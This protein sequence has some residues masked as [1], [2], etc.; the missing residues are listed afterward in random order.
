MNQINYSFIVPV[1]NAEKYIEICLRSLLE[2]TADDYEIILID[3]GSS[4]RSP[5]ICDYFSENYEF[6]HTFHKENGGQV[7][8]RERGIIEAKGKYLCF[9]DSDDYISRDYLEHIDRIN[10]KY[11]SDI[12]IFNWRKVDSEGNVIPHNSNCLFTVGIV[13]KSA[14]FKKIISSSDLNSM[15][16]KV[17]KR[18]LFFPIEKDPRSELIRNGED[19]LQSLPAY[20]RA[21]KFYYSDDEL[22][23]YRMNENSV[24][25]TIRVDEYKALDIVRPIL[26]TYL[27][28]LGFD[29]IDN[30]SAFYLFYADTLLYYIQSCFSS[31]RKR[32]KESLSEIAN[33]SHVKELKKHLIA[34]SIKL[35]HYK[36]IA[37]RLFY[38]KQW[39]SLSIYISILKVLQ[40]FRGTR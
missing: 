14:V 18:E 32:V 24:T 37:L 27:I 39:R 13:D 31:N 10:K 33:Y 36:L 30:V 20:S 8:A 21:E 28:K 1:Y 2:Q 16:T 9:V 17:F 23:Y 22:Y 19:L 12:V 5:F 35:G 40:H 26:Y 38:N 7:S 4:D 15:C 11:N 25:H 6:I 3:D 29:T 34:N